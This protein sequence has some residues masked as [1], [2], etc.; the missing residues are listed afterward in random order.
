M[1][2]K[3]KIALNQWRGQACLLVFV[4]PGTN[5]TRTVTAWTDALQGKLGKAKFVCLFLFTPDDEKV[6][7]ASL[8]ESAPR[9]HL[10]RAEKLATA[11]N[12]VETPHFMVLDVDGGVAGRFTGWGPEPCRDL[13]K[14][15]RAEAAKSRK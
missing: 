11:M 9:D 12:V 13:E 6:L 15:L 10:L 5:L 8:I 1:D 4:R 3:S 7:Q 2:G 14:L